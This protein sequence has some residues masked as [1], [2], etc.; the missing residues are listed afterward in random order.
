VGIAYAEDGAVA[1]RFSDSVKVMFEE[2]KEKEAFDKETYHYEKQFEMAPG[3]YLLKVVFS[4]SAEQLGRLET[5]MVIEPWETA[6]FTIS[7]LALSRSARPVKTAATEFDAELIEN[8]VPLIVGGIQIMPSGS[9]HFKKSEKNYVY[10]EVYEPAMAVPDA[11]EK[12]VPAMAVHLE[13]LDAKSG[14]VKKD[15]GSI[16]LQIP[17]VT[18]NPRVPVGLV[19]TAP[20]LEAGSYRLR[21][22]AMDATGRAVARSAGIQ[23]EN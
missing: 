13:L 8:H 4:S 10:A 14:E 6:Q 22:T 21:V 11:Q 15:F 12:D 1:A 3:K 16:R 19:V 17:P 23:L 20:E 2:K 7:S 9:N 18:G 5:P